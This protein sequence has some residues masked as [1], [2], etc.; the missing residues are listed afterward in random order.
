MLTAASVQVLFRPFCFTACQT[1]MA[2]ATCAMSKLVLYIELALYAAPNVHT[3]MF[4]NL[5][6]T[7]V[8]MQATTN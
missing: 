3:C 7:L 2:P 4:Q 6:P 5:N 1:A 8:L